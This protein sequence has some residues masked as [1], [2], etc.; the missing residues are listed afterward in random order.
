MAPLDVC[1]DVLVLAG[2]IVERGDAKA[3]VALVANYRARNLP[4]LFVPGNHEFHERTVPGAL[5]DLHRTCRRNGITLLHN[6]CVV[7]AG[8]RFFGATLWTDY[9]VVPTISQAE[10]M[11]VARNYMPEHAWVFMP[12]K[13]PAKR[14]R[15]FEPQD[16]LNAH[17]K[18]IRL[19]RTRLSEPFDGPSV[20]ISHQA[21]TPLAIAAKYAGNKANGAFASDLHE[22]IRELAPAVWVFGHLHQCADLRV[23]DTRLFSNPRGY[24]MRGSAQME[25]SQFDVMRTISVGGARDTRA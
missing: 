3:L 17:L 12:L 10:A 24:P 20:V 23:H 15:C 4:I 7:I 6:R 25:N 14:H 11:K 22:L 5:K 21:P 1:G 19:M 9:R 8:V 16:A 2:D 18:S 13:P